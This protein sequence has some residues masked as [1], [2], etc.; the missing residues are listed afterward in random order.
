H[1]IH[2]WNSLGHIFRGHGDVGG[3]FL[4]DRDSVVAG[5]SRAS[6][7]HHRPLGTLY[8]LVASSHLQFTLR[9]RGA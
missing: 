8:L 5:T 9:S 1:L 3:T 7:A 6:H 2:D 4:P